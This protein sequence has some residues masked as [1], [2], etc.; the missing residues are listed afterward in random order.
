MRIPTITTLCLAASLPF[1]VHALNLDTLKKDFAGVR[2]PELPARAASV[3]AGATASERSSVAATV[4]RAGV[5]VNAASAPMLVG[6]IARHTPSVAAVSA[7]TAAALQPKQLAQ[8]SR[9]AVG[10]APADAGEIVA[11]LCKAQPAAFYTVGIAAGDV[12]PKQFDAILDGV[13]TASPAHKALI[14]RARA[15]LGAPKTAAV[16]GSILKRADALLVALSKSTK[17]TP[18][19]ILA[20]DVTTE[21][22]TKL[23]AV[24]VALPQAPPTVGPPYTPSSGSPGEINTSQTFVAPPGGRDYSGP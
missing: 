19:T 6:A 2:A 9:A 21:L 12:A 11:A 3:V 24:A 7:S 8:I 23:A 13:S 18:E 15:E 16:F 22:S 10:A 4:V 20:G 14:A 5:E 1:S 17:S